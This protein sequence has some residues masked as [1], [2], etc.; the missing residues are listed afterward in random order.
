MNLGTNKGCESGNERDEEG[1]ESG[2]KG[3]T[4]GTK[5]MK[6]VV[7]LGTKEMQGRGLWEKTEKQKGNKVIDKVSKWGVKLEKQCVFRRK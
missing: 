3:E 1:C 5:E 4:M 7:N 6:R 2:N